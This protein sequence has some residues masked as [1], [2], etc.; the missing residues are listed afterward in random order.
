MSLTRWEERLAPLDGIAAVVFWVAGITVLQ[1]PA[2]QPEADASPARA[3]AFFQDHTGTVLL[4]TLLVLVGSLFF[5]WFLGLV[6]TRLVASEGGS[7]RLSSIAFAAGVATAVSLILMP[8]V[9]AAGA[10]NNAHLSPDAAQVYLG[11]NVAF[12]VGAE[13]SAAVFLLALGLVSLAAQAFPGWLAWASIILA[14]WLVILPIGWFAM[15]YVFPLWLIAVSLLLA[16]R[17]RSD[18][19]PGLEHRTP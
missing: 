7:H 19:R 1:W 9:H 10:I 17:S 16:T 6:R 4:G 3:L 15:L 14:L 13:M 8:A 11:I 2:H 5:L 18:S 12:F